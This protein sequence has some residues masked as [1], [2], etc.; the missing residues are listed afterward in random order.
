MR[1]VNEIIA[2]LEESIQKASEL[3]FSV[4]QYVP[5]SNAPP[6]EVLTAMLGIRGVLD[7]LDE[8][9][10]HVLRL[11]GRARLV[12]SEKQFAFES[13]WDRELDKIRSA[14]TTRSE[15]TGAKERMS[16]AN[17]A[18]YDAHHLA[19]RAERVAAYA[20]SAAD[21]VRKLHRDV[22]SLRHDLHT[23]IR[24]RAFESNLD[25]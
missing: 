22:D 18:T 5:A 12:A 3:R 15:Y 17:L 13:E 23:I 24:S 8:V 16:E 10:V 14:R 1:S 4:T 25:R 7:A 20:D 21:I 11:R 2:D 9:V 6:D 19:V